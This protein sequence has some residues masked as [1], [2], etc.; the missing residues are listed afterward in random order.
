MY[1]LGDGE[2]E[3]E[4]STW[5]PT[6]NSTKYPGVCKPSNVGTLAA[7][8]ALQTQLNRVAQAKG[9]TKIGVDGD[10]GAG[11]LRIMTSAG[12]IPAG[13]PCSVVAAQVTISTV[14]AKT[15]ADA[16]G[17]SSSVAGPLVLKR[18]TIVDAAGRESIVQSPAI[19]A[20]LVGAFSNLSTPM[21]LA[22]V[23][24]LG[25]IGY[26]VFKDTKKKRRK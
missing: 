14:T 18:P 15:I 3:M 5:Q 17:I 4:G 22:A 6:F 9:L 25:G 21:K 23:G 13:T 1:T 2:I 11:T 7:F 26:F 20:G 8:K 12:M 16:A 19:G 10:I 24:I